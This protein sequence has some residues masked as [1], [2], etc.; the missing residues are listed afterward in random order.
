[1]SAPFSNG[2]E[3]ELWREAWCDTCA[4]DTDFRSDSGT[5][6]LLNLSALCGE[7]PTQWRQGPMWSPQTVIY[8]TAYTPEATA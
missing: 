5:G 2:T 8:C 4:E 6:C 3:Y 7:T 1:M